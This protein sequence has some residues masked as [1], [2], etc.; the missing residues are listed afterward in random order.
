[1]SDGIPINFTFCP[2]CGDQMNPKNDQSARSFAAPPLLADVV[3]YIDDQSKQ[4]R[5]CAGHH[6]EHNRGAEAVAYRSAE[7]L[8]RIASDIKLAINHQ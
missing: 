1:M 5:Q 6:A 2:R 8:E 3:N 7:V 4:F